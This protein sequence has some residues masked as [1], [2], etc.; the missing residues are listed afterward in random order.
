VKVDLKRASVIT[1][2]IGSALCLVLS[3]AGV[4]AA[5][6]TDDKATRIVGFVIAGMFA[7]PLLMIVFSLPRLLQPRGLD[8]DERGIHYW[9]GD[10]RLLLPW[11]ELA[12]VG[13]GYEQ[14][15]SLPSITV[16]DY[17]KGKL[18]DALKL[19]GKRRFAVEIFPHPGVAERYPLMSKFRREQAPPHQ[20]LPAIRWRILVPPMAGAVRAIGNGVQTY[21]PR[22]WLGWFAR[23]WGS[24]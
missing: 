16:E 13:I 6:D 4:Y 20:D 18:E 3:A 24:R 7:L 12:A 22:A 15:P 1:I 9:Q 19:D 10:S 14:P 8:F 5:L 17:L 21:Q 11:P 2:L 23:P